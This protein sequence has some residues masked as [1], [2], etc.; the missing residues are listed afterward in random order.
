MDSASSLA[1]LLATYHN[2]QCHNSVSLATL[3]M[4]YQ[5]HD[6]ITQASNV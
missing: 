1:A 2:T 5:L 6:A 3:P 4:T